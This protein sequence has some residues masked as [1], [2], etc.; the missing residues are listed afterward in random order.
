MNNY[1]NENK[2]IFK[3]WVL[4]AIFLSVVVGIG[5]FFSIYFNSPTILYFAI[6]FSLLMN[7]FSYWFSD[8][9][10]LKISGAKLLQ[11]NDNFELYGI[12][13]NLSQRARLPMPKIYTIPDSSPNAFATGRN[14]KH[15]AIAVTTGL[16]NILDKN[17]LEGVVAHELSHIGNKD[18]LL[19]TVVVVLVG[20]VA[21][22]S[23]MFIRSAIWGSMSK[24]N[25]NN[26]SG[27]VLFIIGLVLAILSP[28]A[29]SLIQLAI[30]RKREFVA[31]SSGAFLTNNP[32]GLANALTKISENSIP[33]KKAN[34][35]TAHMFIS[36]PFKGKNI[37]KIFMTHPPL[38]DRIK[39]L[40]NI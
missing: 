20:F 19:S 27:S 13:Q 17:E 18:I 15:S 33:L 6:G 8:K 28:I 38:E 16:L 31:D 29:V 10:V 14:A 37:G 40:L 2:N 7:F 1:Q 5:W 36:N 9:I 39:N 30:S 35:A 11:K 21:L 25:E 34:K 24:N 22:I 12:V 3:T 26:N 4:M 23:D 32:R